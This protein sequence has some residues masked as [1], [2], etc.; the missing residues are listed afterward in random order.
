MLKR[1]WFAKRLV[2]LA[3]L[4]PLMLLLAAIAAGNLSADPVRD[5][6]ENTGAWTL[7]FLLIT[8]SIT[9]L[10]KLSGWNEII[11][12]RRYPRSS[13]GWRA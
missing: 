2:F 6:T 7:R 1:R 10:R 13:T 11:K 4:A 8:L 5:I 3:C 12:F 9:P